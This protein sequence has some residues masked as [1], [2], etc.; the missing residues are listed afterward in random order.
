M[1]FQYDDGG[2]AAAGFRGSADD[3]VTRSIAIATGLPYREVYNALAKL[4][5]EH[6]LPRS[7]RDGVC[8][9]V[10]RRYL[11]GLRGLGFEWTPLDGRRRWWKVNA[12]LP[13]GALLVSLG[14]TTHQGEWQ[15]HLTA[16]VDGVVRD[17]FDPSD[18]SICR[19]VRAY[20]YYRCVAELEAA[21]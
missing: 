11:S 9:R 16:V 21:A 10:M 19:M 12:D 7:A 18:P 17:V 20:G 2:R 5:H 4:A 15:G 13:D 6:G 3:C 1:R 8:D 14:A